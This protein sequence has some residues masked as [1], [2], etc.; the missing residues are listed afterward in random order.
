MT[1]AD[2]DGVQSIEQQVQS[3]PWLPAHFANCLSVGNLALVMEPPDG[4]L[5]VA[6]AIVSVGGGEADLLNIAVAPD[7]QR[8]GIATCLLSHLLVA[9]ADRADTLF[10][11]AR[12]T[13]HN[14]IHLYDALGFNQVGIRH[15][16]YPARRG[17]EDALIFARTLG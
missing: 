7:H 16:Y 17:R 9:V 15:N 5:P 8:Q 4:P 14:A 12:A 10:L 11:E 13:N 1:A 6:Y 2:L 3:H